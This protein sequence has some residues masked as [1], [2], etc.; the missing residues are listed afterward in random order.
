MTRVVR[1]HDAST[2]NREYY[3]RPEN[4]LSFQPDGGLD[5]AE[6]ALTERFLPSG[7]SLHVTLDKPSTSD[8]PCVWHGEADV[9]IHTGLGDSS[10]VRADS[11]TPEY[12]LQGLFGPGD[13]VSFTGAG[14]DCQGS[15]T[16]Y[17]YGVGYLFSVHSQSSPSTS[18][19]GSASQGGG[20]YTTLVTWQWSLGPQY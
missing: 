2:T 18:L 19:T 7:G 8:D 6:T 9:P 4:R 5:A 14:S 3:E 1:Q 16:W 11:A 12:F 20:P 10:S 17:L 15:G 13:Q